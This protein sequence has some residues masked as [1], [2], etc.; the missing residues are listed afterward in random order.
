MFTRPGRIPLLFSATLT[1]LGAAA[2]LAPSG[3]AS[4]ARAFPVTVHAANG[5][6]EIAARPIA[7]VSLSPTA[8]EML[9]AIGAGSQVKAVDLDSDYPPGV[10]RTQLDGTNPNVEAIASYKPDLVLAS[11]EATSVDTQLRALGITVVSLPPAADLS[12]EY[13]QFAE[14]GRLTGH[15]TAARAEV[16]TIKHQIARIVA[17]VHRAARPR[18]TTTS[19][20]RR[21]TRRPRAPSSGSCWPCSACAASRTPPRAP[22]PTAGTRS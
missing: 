13:A 19:S 15:E 17:S 12:Q 8:T 4:A 3:A 18:P 1:L 5:A 6:V 7:I 14:L 16:G 2:V 10:P 22:P 20:T 11:D 9:Y 21:T